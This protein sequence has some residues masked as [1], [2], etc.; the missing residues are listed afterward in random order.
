M[1]LS[2]Q[3]VN[4]RHLMKRYVIYVLIIGIGALSRSFFCVRVVYASLKLVIGLIWH[5]PTNTSPLRNQFV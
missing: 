1:Q 2:T 4:K 3:H 5:S